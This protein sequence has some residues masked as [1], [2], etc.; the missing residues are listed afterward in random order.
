MKV[1]SAAKG[2]DAEELACAALV[3]DGFAILGRRLRTPL[4]EIDIIAAT[5]AILAFVEVKRRPDLAGAAASLG[6]RQQGRLI[7]AAGY[8]LGE[9]PAW[10][11]ETT[12]FD[13][14]LVDREGRV[15]RIIDAFRQIS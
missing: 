6:R 2:Q 8:L 4:G 10:L 14:I 15:R 13:V 7:A 11:R 12:R 3:R 5:G 9:H 1:T